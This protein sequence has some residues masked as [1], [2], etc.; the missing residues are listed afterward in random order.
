MTNTHGDFI[1]YE[2]MTDNADAAQAF[3]AGLIGWTFKDSGNPEMDYRLF[4]SATAE[5]GGVMSLT[6]EMVS[7]GARPAWLGYIGVD[8]VDSAISAIRAAGGAI[9]MEPWD[10]PDVGRLAFVADPQGAMF[11]VMKGSVEGDV[12]TSFAKHEPMIGHCAW[13]ELAS[14]DPEAAKAFYG[15]QFNWV[16]EGEMDMGPLGKYQF[17][18]A[19]GDSPYGVGAVMPLMPGMPSSAWTFY[20]RV[21]DI[22]KAVAYTAAHGGTALQEPTEIPGGEFSFT[23]LDPQGAVFGLVGPRAGS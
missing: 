15:A 14:A 18:Q 3:Y 8:D 17:W 12:S 16:Q 1:W 19:G 2:L 22:D 6:P 11:Y 20:F 23:G 13:N 10:I 5:V 4:S 7:G 9:H 21:P